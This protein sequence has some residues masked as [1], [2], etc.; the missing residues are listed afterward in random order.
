MNLLESEGRRIMDKLKEIGGLKSIGRGWQEG[1][2]RLPCAVVQ[3]SGERATVFSDD[4]EYLTEVTACVRLYAQNAG[5]L[6]S[7]GKL[8]REKMTEMKYQREFA[9]EDG[10]GHALGLVERYKTW[11]TNNG[12]DED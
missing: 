9:W 2:T 5:E 8:I 3:M 6:E 7:L 10:S 4:R 11:M 1:E 12:K